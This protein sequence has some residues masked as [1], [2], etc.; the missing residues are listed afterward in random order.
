MNREWIYL[1][2]ITVGVVLVQ[3]LVM[4]RIA[5]LDIAPDIL[6]ISVSAVSIQ[7]GR[8]TG[9]VYG[10]ASGFL[11]DLMTGFL[12]VHAFAKT[13]SGFIYGMFYVDNKP[14]TGWYKQQ[15]LQIF[16][17]GAIFHFLVLSFYNHL[18]LSGSVLQFLLKFVGGQTLYTL[19]FAWLFTMYFWNRRR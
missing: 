2:L 13:I 12:G 6:L 1:T 10:F 4:N 14:L 3:F 7:Y 19:L 18:H 5:I 8:T 15:Y 16:A 9:M 11:L 17:I